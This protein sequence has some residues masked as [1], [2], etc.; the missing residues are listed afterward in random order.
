MWKINYY[1]ESVEGEVL[2]LPDT[3][4]AKYIRLTE[5]MQEHGPRLGMP[6]TKAMGDNL[7]ELRLKGREG[8]ARVFYCTVVKQEILMLHMIIKKQQET[9]FKELNLARERLKEVRK[10]AKNT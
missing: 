6:H 3:L 1:N 5:I 9:P 2:N 8:I 7:F 10:N 4:L